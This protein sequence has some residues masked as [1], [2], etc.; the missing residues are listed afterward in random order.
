M[1]DT[2][3]APPATQA[4][5]TPRPKW[6]LIAGIIGLVVYAVFGWILSRNVNAP[7]T[8]P[9][10]DAWRALVGA[11]SLDEIRGPLPWFFQEL[12]QIGG[13]A[14]ML[15]VVPIWLFTI[16]RWRSALFVFA[17]EIGGTMLVSQLVKSLISRPRPAFD[18]ELGL[19]GPLVMVDHGSFPSG[20]AVSTGILIVVVAALLPIAWRRWWW[21]VGVLLAVGMCWQ[22]TLFNAHFLSDAV[23]GIIAGVAF[24]LIVWWLFWPLLEKDRGKPLFKRTAAVTA[25]A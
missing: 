15:L 7:F 9:L 4:S 3:S 25:S 2:H 10:D 17:A 18:A 8:Q 5:R 12:G 24:S 1:T 19:S 11:S 21:I 14:L 6:P 16:R 20:H 23:M 13:M 22:R